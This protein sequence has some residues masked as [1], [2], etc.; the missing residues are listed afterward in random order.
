MT[1]AT[2]ALIVICNISGPKKLA[3]INRKVI[4]VY[5]AK[6]SKGWIKPV[7]AAIENLTFDVVQK[8]KVLNP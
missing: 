7:T 2:I 3:S 4:N 1:A 5:I 6:I 8:T